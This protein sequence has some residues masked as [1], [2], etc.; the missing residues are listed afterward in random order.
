MAV[1]PETQGSNRAGMVSCDGRRSRVVDAGVLSLVDVGK[2]KSKVTND[3]GREV[4]AKGWQTT[5]YGTL[6]LPWEMLQKMQEV[7]ILNVRRRVA[8]VESRK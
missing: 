7:K 1:L 8:P 3:T 6:M 5:G 2:S 4:L